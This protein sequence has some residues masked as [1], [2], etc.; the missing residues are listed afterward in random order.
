MLLVQNYDISDTFDMKHCLQG[1]P[2]LLPNLLR[3][4]LEYRVFLPPILDWAL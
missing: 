3:L 1:L 4:Q 2:P